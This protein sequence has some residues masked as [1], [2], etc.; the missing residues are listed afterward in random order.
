MASI[1]CLFLPIFLVLLMQMTTERN[2]LSKQSHK[3]SRIINTALDIKGKKMQLH[4]DARN[5]GLA[6]E[7]GASHAP[8]RNQTRTVMTLK[9]SRQCSQLSSAITRKRIPHWEMTISLLL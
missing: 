6:K 7:Q 3:L 2:K 8:K 5:G 4:R 1:L 9:Q